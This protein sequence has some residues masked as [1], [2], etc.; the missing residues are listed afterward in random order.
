MTWIRTY[1]TNHQTLIF[2]KQ[3][4]EERFLFPKFWLRR[5]NSFPQTLYH[6]NLGL[7]NLYGCIIISWVLDILQTSDNQIPLHIKREKQ[8]F[9]IPLLLL[10]IRLVCLISFPLPPTF[11]STRA[12]KAGIKQ[13]LIPNPSSNTYTNLH[14]IFSW[15]LLFFQTFIYFL[16][17]IAQ[18]FPDLGI[19]YIAKNLTNHGFYSILLAH[20]GVWQGLDI[21]V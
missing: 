19:F 20:I 21:V 1:R 17:R 5:A 14:I 16:L 18:I 13:T 8:R 9:G 12:K 3:D 10:L 15:F 4:Y 6:T 7:S 11:R 2:S